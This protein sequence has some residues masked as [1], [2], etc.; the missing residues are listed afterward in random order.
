MDLKILTEMKHEEY[1]ICWRCECDAD[2]INTDNGFVC[3]DCSQSLADPDAWVET[4]E[5]LPYVGEPVWYFSECY[6]VW[7]GYFKGIEDGEWVFGGHGCAGGEVSHW[8]PREYGDTDKPKPPY[9]VIY[10]RGRNGLLYLHRI[11]GGTIIES[12][13]R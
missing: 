10:R 2:L 9:G 11:P 7:D 8:K 12:P 1:G 4:T 3:H 5:R 6:G 13:P